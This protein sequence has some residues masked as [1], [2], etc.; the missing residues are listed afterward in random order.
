MERVHLTPDIQSCRRQQ[1]VV[2]SGK[3]AAWSVDSAGA[4]TKVIA[5]HKA[6]WFGVPPRDRIEALTALF[7]SLDLD[8]SPLYKNQPPCLS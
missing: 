7:D 3:C 8:H 4:A 1:S 5:A 2:M 6:G